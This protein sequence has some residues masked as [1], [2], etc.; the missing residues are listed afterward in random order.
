MK[1]GAYLILQRTTERKVKEKR[2]IFEKG[3]E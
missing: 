3:N 1:P 2:V